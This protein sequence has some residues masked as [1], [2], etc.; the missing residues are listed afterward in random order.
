MEK[1]QLKEFKLKVLC[2]D[3]PDDVLSKEQY[4]YLLKHAEDFL[5][6]ETIWHL[7]DIEWDCSGAGYSEDK[8]AAVNNFYK[9]PVWLLNGIFTE[10]DSESV[11]HRNLIA[12]W[13]AAQKPNLVIDFGGGYGSLA[14]K[15]SQRCPD[16]RVAIVEPHPTKLA[17]RLTLEYP[18]LFFISELPQTAD[19]V[20][21]QDVLE[22]VP[23]PLAI[24]AK[25]LQTTREG[26]FLI[27]A[28][29]FYPVI[30]CHLP[31]TFHFRYSFHLIVPFLGCHFV[32][33]VPGV[34]HAQIFR[35]VSLK[36][37]N[38][39]KIRK[40]EYASK[41]AFP[42]LQAGIFILKPIWRF[43]RRCVSV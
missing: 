15:I 19:V 28:N 3:I 12:D 25:L 21:A 33:T 37:I 13:V 24:C 20:I 9:S 10:C 6:I 41:M 11:R 39:W 36:E 31:S 40:M 43:A 17:K 18:K 35:R 16:T 30:K 8:L 7:M 32:G 14:R 29:C 34:S 26:G 42:L 22:H 5:N 38:W 1:N 2:L 27:T 4:Q 23:D